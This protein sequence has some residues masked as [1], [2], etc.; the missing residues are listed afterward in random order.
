[1]DGGSLDLS[2]D[3]EGD[4]LTLKWIERGGPRIAAAP[5]Q[6][7]FGSKLVERSVSQQL[8]GSIQSEWLPEGAIVTLRMSK[9]RLAL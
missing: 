6:S 4:A 7:G 1:V 9:S 5:R 2:C 8:G 3:E